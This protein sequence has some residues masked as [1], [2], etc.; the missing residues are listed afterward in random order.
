MVSLRVNC[1]STDF[2]YCYNHYV[3]V[4]VGGVSRHLVVLSCLNQYYEV[5]QL[6]LALQFNLVNAV[7]DVNDLVQ[8]LQAHSIFQYNLHLIVTYYLPQVV[9]YFSFHIFC[10]LFSYLLL[11]LSLENQTKR[12]QS[13]LAGER[14]I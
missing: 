7:D 6:E 4:N 14:T 2:H 10:L 13:L 11:L 9:Y 3:R 5:T 1:H 8:N 12:R